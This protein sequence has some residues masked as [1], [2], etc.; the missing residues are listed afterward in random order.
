MTGA[1]DTVPKKTGFWRHVKYLAQ[2]MAIQA[3]LNTCRMLPLRVSSGFGAML[4]RAV[5]P[6]LKA[7]KV[8]RRNLARVFPEW[9]QARIDETVR[10]MW[11]NLGR[12]AG[13]FSQVD[14]IDTT[15]PNGPVQIVGLEN[16]LAA[17]DNGAFVILAAH[18]GNWEMGCLIP[19][20]Y[21]CPVNAVYRW[22]DNPWMDRYFRRLRGRFM[23]R[24]IP[25]GAAGAREAF[26][27]LK[28]GEP[29]GLLLDQ[30]LNE[31]EPVPFFGRDAYTATA[32]V[33][34]ALRVGA[35]M[36]PV[37]FERVGKVKFLVTIHPPLDI[38]LTG[39]RAADAVTVAKAFNAML[40]S[41]IRERPGQWFWVHKRW[42]DS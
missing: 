13:E 3:T 1:A 24:L 6:F 27:A 15:D 34:M 16:L 30:K 36:L 12:G 18:M 22:A 23:R 38:P 25:K 35:P 4:F 5:G 39:D 10:E 40:E 31:G 33:S 37:R 29:L 11:D 19:A 7:D 42:P 32:G 17:R 8:A 2:A 20:Q 26:S 41:W 14:L 21:G 9:D 28:R